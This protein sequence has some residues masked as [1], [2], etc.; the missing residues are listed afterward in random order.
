[1]KKRQNTSQD[2]AAL[3][4][5]MSAV[6]IS[7]SIILLASSFKAAPAADELGAWLSPHPAKAREAGS[8]T[9]TGGLNI[10]REGHTATLLPT[11]KVLVAGG[12]NNSVILSSAE[13]YD[14]ATGPGRHRQ[15]RPPHARSH[16]DAAAHRQGAGGGRILM[17]LRS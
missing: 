9:F 12:D 16:G 10:A 11:G 3:R 4:S 2:A 7:I 15:P 17:A 8:W 14:P 1:M 5:T 6:L 13:L